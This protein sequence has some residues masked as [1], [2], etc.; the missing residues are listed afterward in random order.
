MFFKDSV[1]N[2][3]S[4]WMDGLDGLGYNFEKKSSA[5]SETSL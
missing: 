1:L 4:K 3:T 2:E 5:I